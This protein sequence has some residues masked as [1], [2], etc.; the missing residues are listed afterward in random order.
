MD[1]LEE[2]VKDFYRAYGKDEWERLKRSYSE[3][4]EFITTRRY[5]TQYLPEEGL[6]LDA[7]GGP[8]RYTIELA[9]RGY[10]VILL[11]LT[12][13]QLTIAR[14]RIEEVGVGDN[15]KEIVEGNI[16]DLSR[17]DDETFD[18]VLCLGGPLSHIVPE[19]GRKKAVIALK[20]VAKQGA[21]IFISI[22]G[23]LGV[24]SRS[25][26]EF[27]EEIGR[28]FFNAYRDTGTYLGGHGFAP[29]HLFRRKELKELVKSAGLQV[30][31]EV[32]LEGLASSQ[33]EA[34]N[35]MCEED[36]EKWEEWK[37]IHFKTC[38]IP[39]VVD[40]SKHMLVVARKPPS[41]DSDS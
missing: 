5:L 29:M 8:G 18:A 17:F 10:S 23:R 24:L 36:E 37:K 28:D 40:T 39:S 27:P 19:K 33:K 41:L 11:D 4:L 6:I 12:P 31:T 38:E 35:Q 34:F 25:I 3:R 21:P 20:R 32:G 13:K 30:I 14:R 7:G 2:D 16:K 15:V 9:K 26:G 1:E 22:M